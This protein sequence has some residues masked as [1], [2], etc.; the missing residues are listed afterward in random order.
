MSGVPGAGKSTIIEQRYRPRGR[1]STVVLDLDAELATHPR[2]DP[3]DPDKLYFEGGTSAYDWADQRMETRFVASLANPSV[4]RIVIDGTGTN[5][6]RQTRRMRAAREAGWFVKVIYV[7]IPIETAVRRAAVR[8]R[9]ISAQRVY[10]YQGRIGDALEHMAHLADEFEIFDAPSHDP[11]HVLMQEGFVDQSRTLVAAEAEA[12]RRAQ[13][14][15]ISQ[16]RRANQRARQH[17]SHAILPVARI[18]D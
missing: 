14:S 3:A 2:Y 16:I 17:D 18:Q 12:K 9:P 15:R 4:R 10:M 5:A 1:K 11:A 8:A 13:M 7:H 6:E